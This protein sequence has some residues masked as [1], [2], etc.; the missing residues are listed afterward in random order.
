MEVISDFIR[1]DSKYNFLANSYNSPLWFLGQKYETVEHA[2]QASKTN[3]GDER[4]NIRRA[5]T[6]KQAQELGSKVRLR[7]G[8]ETERLTLM[9][10]LIK[11]KFKD[12]FLARKLLATGDAIIIMKNDYGDDFWGQATDKGKNHL[13]EILM[14]VRQEIYLERYAQVIVDIGSYLSGVGWI[15]QPNGDDIWDQC[16]AAP[17]N[18]DEWFNI[19]DAMKHESRIMSPLYKKSISEGRFFQDKEFDIDIEVV[20][21]FIS[22]P[23]KP[24]K[25]QPVPLIED[26][27]EK[28]PDKKVQPTILESNDKKVVKPLSDKEAIKL[29]NRHPKMSQ[30]LYRRKPDTLFGRLI[31]YVKDFLGRFFNL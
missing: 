27:P 29:I 25:L 22:E 1:I 10:F 14:D 26:L 31:E 19:F 24:I 13:G 23:S 8:W 28:V 16:W 7:S 4:E 21:T 5:F 20:D 17:W 30:P 2:Y 11:T 18:N 15:R 6:A 3:N 9:K 12:S